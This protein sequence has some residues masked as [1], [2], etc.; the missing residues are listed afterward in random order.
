M[1]ESVSR[2]NSIESR[3]PIGL[4]LLRISVFLVLLMWALDK[5][6]RPQHAAAVY[7]NFYF[8]GGLG[9]SIFYIIGI[10]Q[11][12]I[13]VLFVLGLWKRWTYGLV[14]FMHAVSTF[15]AFRQY[16]NPFQDP[17][18]LF[19]A[20]WPMLAACFVL[21]YLKD[22]DTKFTLGGKATKAADA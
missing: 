8:L 17:N 15:S 5:L 7:E 6:V 9:N 14:L 10:V 16:F 22:W 1:R 21:F 18:L 13:I 11:L 3:L 4:F 20:A 12:A 19:F 2:H